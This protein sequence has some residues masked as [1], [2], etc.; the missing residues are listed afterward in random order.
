MRIKLDE[1]LPARLATSLAS[2]GHDTDTVISEGIQGADDP[3]VWSAAQKAGRLLI[4]QD[5]DFSD[6]RRYRPGTHYGV[7]LVRLRE[8]GRQALYARVLALFQK[9]DSEEMAR[10]FCVLTDSKFRIRRE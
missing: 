10:S 4:T 3:T 9:V 7:L 6:L 5:L 2:L 8:P 1:N